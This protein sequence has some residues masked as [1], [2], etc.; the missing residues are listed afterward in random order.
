MTDAWTG[1]MIRTRREAL[2]LSQAAVAEQAGINKETYRRYETGER[3]PGITTARRIAEIL[4]LSLAEVAGQVPLSSP[5][6]AQGNPPSV[7]GAVLHARRTELGLSQTRVAASMS[8][9]VELY[10]DY[11]NGDK[12]IPLT[13]AA[14]L[15]S[16]LDM[17]LGK[18]A[19][20]EH[21]TAN[22]GGRWHAHWEPPTGTNSTGHSV[23]ALRITNTLVL[24]QGWRGVLEI[25][26]EELLIGWY[27]PPGRGIRTRTS[28]FLW[29]PA[30]GDYLYG[31][32]TGITET[33]SVASGW[34]VLARD[35]TR[36][37]NILTELINTGRPQAGPNLRIPRLG[38][39]GS[40]T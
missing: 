17:S 26:H 5:A 1:D 33:N 2:R 23:E 16:V 37:A 8:I 22:L 4:D 20:T 18:L 40:A 11:E 10:Q 7:V 34:C 38:G 29:I 6:S 28:M 36:S 15:A 25:S 27:R 9:P 30:A 31:R 21:A 12:E 14:E 24:D 13:V 19:G 32:W 39:W 3:E 35:D